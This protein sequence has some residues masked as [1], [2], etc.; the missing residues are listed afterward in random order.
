MSQLLVAPRLDTVHLEKKK[1]REKG[2]PSPSFFPR[3]ESRTKV[4][5]TASY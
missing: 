2:P 5:K 1:E 3:P 4:N